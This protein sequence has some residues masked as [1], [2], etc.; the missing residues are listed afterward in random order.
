MMTTHLS[1]DRD[2]WLVKI[3]G[4]LAFLESAFSAL[5]QADIGQKVLSHMR[6]AVI[7]IRGALRNAETPQLEAFT[8]DLEDLFDRLQNGDLWLTSEIRGVLR[9]CTRALAAAVEALHRGETGE[10]EVQCIRNE[11]F[12]ILLVNAVTVKR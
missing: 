7:A 2:R 8:C 3:N 4:Q 10:R 12:S 11:L 5:K 1:L 9:G 6:R